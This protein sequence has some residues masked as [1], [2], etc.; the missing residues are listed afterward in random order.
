MTLRFASGLA[1]GLAKLIG[2][3][4]DGGERPATQPR[5]PAAAAPAEPATQSPYV[6]APPLLRC[7][8][9]WSVH[10]RTSDRVIA[11]GLSQRQAETLCMVLDLACS[12]GR[13]SPTDALH[14]R[15]ED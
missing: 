12:W 10:N 6:V 1:A 2:L 11:A 3:A 5:D 4:R 13:D 8:G 9:G 14:R 7:L 15:E